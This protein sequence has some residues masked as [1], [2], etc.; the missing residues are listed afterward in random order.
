[1]GGAAILTTVLPIS[2]SPIEALRGLLQIC[3]S[4]L[5]AIQNSLQSSSSEPNVVLPTRADSGAGGGTLPSSFFDW[6][7]MSTKRAP[8]PDRPAAE[9]ISMI[10]RLVQLSVLVRY[11]PLVDGQPGT[12]NVIRQALELDAELDS[13]ENRQEGIWTVTEEHANEGFFPAGS[14]FEDCYHVYSNMHTARVWS[15]LRWAR[16]MVSQMLLESVAM[17]PLSSSQLVPA[18]HQ[19]RSYTHIKRLV[20]DILVSIPTHYRHPNLKPEHYKFFDEGKGGAHIGIAG[21]PSLLFGIKV[22]SCAPGVPHQYRMWGL[23]ILETVWCD[24]GMFQAKMLADLV[25]K[26]IEQDSSRV[27]N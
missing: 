10:V 9:L 16:V 5:A 2:T 24:T 15:H 14:V 12:A 26:K 22:A 3:F 11:R 21:I 25:R 1:M 7:S 4:I 27:G 17:L 19:K 20:R 13:W 18:A 23:R 8:P 6:I